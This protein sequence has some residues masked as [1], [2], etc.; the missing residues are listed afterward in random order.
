MYDCYITFRSITRAQH[1]S[2]LF[3]TAEISHQL[4]RTPKSIASQGCGYALRV[5]YGAVFQAVQ[6]LRQNEVGFLRVYCGESGG[7]WEEMQV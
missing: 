4:I 3:N 1:G 2:A 7:R 6:V 5:H